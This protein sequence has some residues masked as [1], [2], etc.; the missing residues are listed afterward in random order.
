ML[1][2]LIYLTIVF[3][4]P[5]RLTYNDLKGRRDHQSFLWANYWA[6]YAFVLLLKSLLP[7]LQ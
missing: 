7:F 3:L 6:I 2:C 5:A 1:A 4:I